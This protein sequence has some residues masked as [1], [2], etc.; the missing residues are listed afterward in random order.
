VVVPGCVCNL[1][2]QHAAMELLLNEGA[3][4]NVRDRWG[5]TVLQEALMGKHEHAVK[6]LM[7][8]SANVFIDNGPALLCTA[9]SEVRA[10]G[11]CLMFHLGCIMGVYLLAQD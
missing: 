6:L 4:V 9:A 1:Q 10:R 2:G 3:S 7:Q 11:G 8:W 5:R